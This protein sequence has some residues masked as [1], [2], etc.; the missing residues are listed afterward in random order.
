MKMLTVSIHAPHSLML[1]SQNLN[2]ITFYCS[3]ISYVVIVQRCGHV[4][5]TCKATAIKFVTDNYA[6]ALKPGPCEL[7]F[8]FH[9]GRLEGVALA[10]FTPG[11]ESLLI[12]IQST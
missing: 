7:S 1:C 8:T 12:S 3:R 6:F 9:S 10:K 5:Q 11:A 4:V 2:R